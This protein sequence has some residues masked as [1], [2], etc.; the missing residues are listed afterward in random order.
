MPT[1]EDE[2][3]PSPGAEPKTDPDAAAELG[4]EAEPD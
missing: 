2:Q 4:G 1:I 3:G